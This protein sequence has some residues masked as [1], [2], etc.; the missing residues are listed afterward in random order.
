[1]Y[2]GTIIHDNVPI[3][4]QIL[5]ESCSKHIEAITSNLHC[6]HEHDYVVLAK[7]QAKLA[8]ADILLPED[9]FHFN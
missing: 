4:K 6:V 3:T 1:M 9:T 2:N 8:Y 7:A 5:A